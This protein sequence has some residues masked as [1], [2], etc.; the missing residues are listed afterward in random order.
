MPF[1]ARFAFALWA[2]FASPALAESD[3]ERSAA[4]PAE[5]VGDVIVRPPP[6]AA[7]P[8]N[9]RWGRETYCPIIESAAALRGLPLD[10]F[11]RLIH[12]ESGMNPAA[13]SHKGA[14]G[15]AQFM[16]GTAASYGL[17][18]PFDPAAAIDAQA[19]L[20]SDLL[21]RFR[22]VPLALAAYNA[23]PGAVRRF[24]GIPPYAE[25]QNYVRIVQQNAAS[26]R[27]ASATPT[28]SAPSVTPYSP[29]SKPSEI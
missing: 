6:A 19:H 15:I 8:P 3:A 20:M 2:C 28:S 1:A 4:F 22:S 13:V 23:G 5:D 25:T 17:R 14:Q 10:F 21:R 24:G 16:P 27:S 29:S 11:V 12:Q 26:F 18:N 7:A 9:V